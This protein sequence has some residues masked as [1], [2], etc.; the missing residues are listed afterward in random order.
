MHT[1]HKL[2]T[3]IQGVLSLVIN[4]TV[5]VNSVHSSKSHRATAAQLLDAQ[6]VLLRFDFETKKLF[7]DTGLGDAY[8]YL[9][10]FYLLESSAE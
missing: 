5:N 4:N 1:I 8:S 3:R 6:F 10:N 7:H 9:L 2:R